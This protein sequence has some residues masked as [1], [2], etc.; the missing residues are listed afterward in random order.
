MVFTYADQRDKLLFAVGAVAASSTGILIP[1][2]MFVFG[3]IINSYG[4]VDND[5]SAIGQSCLQIFYI[6]LGVFAFSF[7]YFTTLMITAERIA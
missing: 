5:F 6:S 7:T 3:N 2:T 1:S 4:I